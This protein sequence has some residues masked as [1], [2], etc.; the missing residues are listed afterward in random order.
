MRSSRV[1]FGIILII[2]SLAF[3]A[4]AQIPSITREAYLTGLSSP[5]HITNAGDGTNRMFVLQQRG[6]IRVVQ[7]G[8]TTATTFMDLSGKVS[9]SGNERGLLGL[10][11]HPDF[12]NN[13]FFFVNYT[14]SSDGATVIERY[15]ATNNNTTGDINSAQNVITISQDFSNHNGGHIEFGPDG[16]LY[17][18]MGDGGSGNDPNDRAQNINSLLGKMLRITPTLADTV[19]S[20]PY[21]VPADNPFVGVNGAD[22]IFAIGLRNPYRWSFDRGGTNQ[23]WTGDVGQ[24]SI[25]EV[26]IVENGG[27]Y[28]WRVYEGNSCTN[29]D[30]GDCTPSNYDPPEFQYNHSQGRCSITGGYVYRGTQGTLPLGAYMYGD[31]CSGQY[32]YWDGTNQILIEDSPRNISS[33]GQDEAGELYLVHRSGTVEKIVNS[34]S[35][36]PDATA[37]FDGDGKTDLSVFRP[38]NGVW[39]IY[40]SG[41][42]DYNISQFGATDDVPVP[43]DYDGDGITDLAVF[44]PSTAEW[45]VMHSGDSTIDQRVFG[46]T[47][48]IPVP[49]DY[50]N[51]DAIDFGVFTPSIGRWRITNIPTGSNSGGFTDQDF[52]INNDIPVPGDYDGDGKTELAVYRP[53]E[54]IWY[55]VGLSETD[56]TQT[57]WGISTDIPAPGDFDGDGKVDLTVYRPSEGNWYTLQSADSTIRGVKWGIAE[58]IPVTGDY[59]GDGKADNAIWRPSTGEW[60]VLRSSEFSYFSAPLG[61][62]TDL[63]IPRYDIK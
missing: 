39:Y 11:F 44:R 16:N 15:E 10:A 12:E 51:D 38:S 1:L 54:G 9:Q 14:R 5:V 18:G 48:D 49:G 63:P 4:I 19:G 6:L 28:G 2:L 33:F 42:N 32:Y 47:G 58:D 21:T 60:F 3:S 35:F 7:P 24:F 36:A 41:S 61:T 43:K 50:G 56:H 17:I 31:F 53:S 29:N 13:N 37:D 57:S 62:S 27:N 59:D 26:T 46:Q 34:E 25:E 23:L 30:P 55:H 45:F 8:S 22:E 52:G 20:V 40:N